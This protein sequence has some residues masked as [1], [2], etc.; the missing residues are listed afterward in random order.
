MKKINVHEAKTHLSRYLEEVERGETVVI[1]RRNVPI[2]ELRRLVDAGSGR[3]RPIGKGKTVFSVPDS[4][5][6]PLPEELVESFEGS[7]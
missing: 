6:E 1:C 7:D 2:A 3:R 5:F 4:F